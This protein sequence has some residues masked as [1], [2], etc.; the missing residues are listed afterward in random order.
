MSRGSTDDRTDLAVWQKRLSKA[1]FQ[2]VCLAFR[3]SRVFF[4][5]FLF[6]LV[7]DKL[8]LLLQYLELLLVAGV[9]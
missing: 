3:T 1:G 8:L 7:L 2:L 9:V 5:L 6:L 4:L